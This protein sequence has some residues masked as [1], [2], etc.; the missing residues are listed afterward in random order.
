M[1]EVL[2]VYGTLKSEFQYDPENKAARYLNENSLYLKK[3]T[4]QGS[5]YLIDNIYP[6]A[7]PSSY[8]NYKV[9]G[10]VFELFNADK[11]LATLDEYEECS[12]NFPEPKLFKRIKTRIDCLRNRRFCGYDAW[13][14]IYNRPVGGLREIKPG[15]FRKPK[16]NKK[17]KKNNLLRGE[18][19]E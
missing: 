2:F 7:V 6:G 10:E 14:Y 18:I 13:I 3:A 11:V 16:I 4:F 12:D 8:I 5:L 9:H 19:N 15:I 1:S 17:S